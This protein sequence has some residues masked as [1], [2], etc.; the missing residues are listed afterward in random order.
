MS[1]SL[2]IYVDTSNE[3]YLTEKIERG[4]LYILCR[5]NVDDYEGL[6][7]KNGKIYRIVEISNFTWIIEVEDCPVSINRENCNFI[8]IIKGGVVNG[9]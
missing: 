1:S 4:E 7:C 2:Q 5:E 3:E 8:L 6:Y 9:S